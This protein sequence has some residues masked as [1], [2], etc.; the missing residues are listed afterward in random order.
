MQ[1]QE[2]CGLSP[3]FG[4]HCS[5]QGIKDALANLRHDA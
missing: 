5:T 3:D 1:P 4:D 2:Q